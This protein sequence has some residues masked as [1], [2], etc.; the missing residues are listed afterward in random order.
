MNEARIEISMQKKN[1]EIPS[2]LIKIAKLNERP[3]PISVKVDN[4]TI[5]LQ[6]P[7]PYHFIGTHP[8]KHP[9]AHFTELLALPH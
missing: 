1:M 7:N 6:Q 2:E 3:K 5:N 9:V 4:P 8:S